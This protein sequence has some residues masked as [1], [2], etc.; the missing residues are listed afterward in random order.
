[1][2]EGEDAF[3]SD[4][5]RVSMEEALK[6][7]KELTTEIKDEATHGHADYSSRR[8]SEL[9]EKEKQRRSLAMEARRSS[10]MAAARLDRRPTLGSEGAVG[11][12]EQRKSESV[13]NAD[14]STEVPVADT[15]KTEGEGTT[16]A[17]TPA[18]DEN[19]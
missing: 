4:A 9:M 15:A 16:P 18:P 19:V 10:A 7:L 11:N 2:A 17:S 1:M 5:P 3:E 13:P 12:E 14:A 8:A 6:T